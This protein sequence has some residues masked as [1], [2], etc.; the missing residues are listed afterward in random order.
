[1]VLR[2]HPYF[3]FNRLKIAY[4]KFKTIDGVTIEGE[5]YGELVDKLREGSLNPGKDIEDYKVETSRRAYMQN[6]SNVR[7]DT[8]ENFIIDLELAGLIKHVN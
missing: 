3:W 4:M 1:M 5:T 2:S 7:T 8:N 6:G